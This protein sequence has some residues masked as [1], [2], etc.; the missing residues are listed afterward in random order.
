MDDKLYYVGIGASAGG[1][2]ALEGLFKAMPQDTGL[3]FIVIQH[4][5]PDYKSLM[6][7]LLARHTKMEILVAE[8]GMT[9]KAN[10]IYLIPPRNNLSIFHGKLYLEEQKTYQHRISLPIDIFFRSLAKDQEKKAI[11]IVL[12]GT[13]SDG[14]LGVRAIKEAGGMVM[15]QDEESA[16]F[17]GM[18]RSSISTGIVDYVLPPQKMPEE[19]LNYIKHPSIH[20]VMAYKA[21]MSDDMDDIAKICMILRNFGGIDFSNYKN[22]TMLRRIERRIKINREQS[23]EGYISLLA[24]SDQEKEIL[25]R[26][27]LI[28][29]TAFFR[30]KEAFDSILENVLPKLDYTKDA[31]RI[32]SAACSTGEEVYSLAITVSEYMEE[33]HHDCDLKIFAT[34]VDARALETAGIGYYPESLVAD[35]APALITKYFDAHS[36]GYQIKESLRKMVVFAKHNILKDPPF[37]KLDLLVCRNFFIYLKSHIQQEILK[38]FY[39]SLQTNGYLFMGSSESTGD[40]AEAFEVVDSKWKIF[41]YKDGYKPAISGNLIMSPDVSYKSMGM[42]DGRRNNEGV[43]YERLLMGILENQIDP[44]LVIDGRDNIVQVIGDVSPFVRLQPGRFSHNFNANMSKELSLFVNNILRR[45]RLEEREILFSNLA[46]YADKDQLMTVKGQLVNVNDSA[47]YVI[48]FTEQ[49][50]G[51]KNDIVEVD[52]TAEVKERVKQLEMELQIAKESLQATIEELETSN[53]ELQS[54]NEELIASNEEL[55]STNEEL[56]SV[57]EELYTVNNEHQSK[58]DELT[59]MTSDLTN[60]LKNTEVGAL[61]LDSR[62]CIRKLTPLISEVTNILDTDV[63]RPISHI[64]ALPNYPDIVTDAMTVMENLQGIEKEIFSKDGTSYLTRIRPYRSEYNAVEGVIITM[65]DITTLKEQQKEMDV[66]NARLSE[67]MAL[68]NIAWWEYDLSTG[69]VIYSDKKATMLGYTVEEFPNDVYEICDLIHED[70]YD[71]TMNHMRDYLEGKTAQWNL[72]YRIKRKDGT[73]AFYHDVGNIVER[74]KDGR[75]LKLVGSVIDVSEIRD[76]ED[77][78]ALLGAESDER[79]AKEDSSDTGSK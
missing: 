61:Y 60:L 77:Q 36:E 18:P 69:H 9:T 62:L 38:N 70:D 17:D 55:Q 43:R 65:I 72:T 39:H 63:G 58:I 19:L 59:S 45:L 37:S 1:L 41:K 40:M 44:S 16:K 23:V 8:D 67:A 74:S 28:G 20:D 26:E 4:L 73:Y 13:G 33:H 42:E 66:V 25:Q 50:M 6:N 56:Q 53:E 5:A 24:D 48:S 46:P 34:D 15:V 12:S 52:M 64:A 57:N 7:E 29:V 54:S 21:Q 30:D 14:T 11:G 78:L 3:T 2:E 76:L 10:T 51:N 75:P 32:W 49:E 47:F 31:I 35:I 68:G 22:N 71:R 79:H 27:L